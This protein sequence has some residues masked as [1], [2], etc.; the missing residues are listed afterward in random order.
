MG[1]KRGEMDPAGVWEGEVGEGG[2]GG[3]HEKEGGGGVEWKGGVV[4]VKRGK[5]R[6]VADRLSNISIP[7][8]MPRG[9]PFLDG[10]LYYMS[11]D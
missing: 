10:I 4:G 5:K 11:S 1:G 3:G 7:Y 8:P 2:G 9:I 6:R